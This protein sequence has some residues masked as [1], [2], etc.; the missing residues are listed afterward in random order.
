[1]KFEYLS[2]NIIICE[3]FLPPMYL[4]DIKI[5]LLNNR[6]RFNIPTWSEQRKE[7]GEIKKGK[8]TKEFFSQFCGGMDY[9]IDFGEVMPGNEKIMDL[10]KWFYSQ[11]LNA[12]FDHK[13]P[14]DVFH[15][16]KK[17]KTHKI[18]VISYNNGGYY[19]WHSD[20]EFFTFNLILNEGDALSGGDLFFMDDGKIIKVPNKDNM[21]VLFPW[22]IN[23][24]ITPIRS[25][26]GKDVPF[27]QQRF[28]IQYW[29]DL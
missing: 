6:K 28:S 20:T 16:L 2:S 14:H 13:T 29:V 1:M 24:S 10:S 19:N 26:D 15:L 4:Q 7:N 18:H 3:N 9:W 17:P 11:G 25:K 23:H 22:Y 27:P 12:F 8:I 5:E 21:M